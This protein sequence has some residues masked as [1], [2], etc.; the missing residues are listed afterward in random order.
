MPDE[1]VPNTRGYTRNFYYIAPA[2]HQQI[3]GMQQLC[4]DNVSYVLQTVSSWS[5][6]KE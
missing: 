1:S 5:P 6:I 4:H 2:Q 3:S